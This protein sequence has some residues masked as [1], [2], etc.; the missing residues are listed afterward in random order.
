MKGTKILT[1][2]IKRNTNTNLIF[3]KS[4]CRYISEIAPDNNLSSTLFSEKLKLHKQIP[5]I[6]SSSDYIKSDFDYSLPLSKFASITTNEGDQIF[7]SPIVLQSMIGAALERHDRETLNLIILEASRS[8]YL[9]SSIL[10]TS[11]KQCLDSPVRKNNKASSI[12]E[13]EDKI[14][15]YDYHYLSCLNSAVY[16]L[17]HCISNNTNIKL[18]QILCQRLLGELVSNCFWNDS[19]SVASYMISQGHEFGDREIFFIIGGLMRNSDG[20]SKIFELITLINKY[21]R[22]DIAGLFSYTKA[23]RY[24]KSMTSNHSYRKEVAADVIERSMESSIK[25]IENGWF[26]F[27]LSKMIVALSCGAGKY[28]LADVYIQNIVKIVNNRNEKL[29][30]NGGGGDIDLLSVLRGFS[31]GAGVACKDN[32]NYKGNFTMESPVSR[33]ILQLSIEN[34]NKLGINDGPLQCMNL[35]KMYWVLN[36]RVKNMPSTFSSLLSQPT[37]P[38]SESSEVTSI[39][40]QTFKYLHEPATSIKNEVNVPLD[41]DEYFGTRDDYFQSNSIEKSS[42]TNV[43]IIGNVTLIDLM[44]KQCY[45]DLMHFI[46]DSSRTSSTFNPTKGNFRRLFRILCDELGL[47]HKVTNKINSENGQ[48]ILIKVWKSSNTLMDPPSLEEVI[49]RD[50]QRAEE[51][52]KFDGEQANWNLIASH[53]MVR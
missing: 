3:V 18:N 45:N 13:S 47:Q 43:D 20:V 42:D 6:N 10:E 7:V 21:N 15:N 2:H 8:G 26:S 28:N 35:F 38:F 25:A 51:R 44:T 52:R 30:N 39:M 34:L 48:E 53:L 46:K 37:P 31:Q 23:N 41:Q 36:Y 49:R 14:N 4:L 24:A 40:E 11:I 50:C 5:P 33:T 16:L 29:E 9:T 22:D 19:Y 27:S 12:L 17:N 32:L 1:R